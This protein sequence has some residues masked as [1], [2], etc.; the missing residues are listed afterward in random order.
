MCEP[1]LAYD[2]HIKKFKWP[3]Q[4]LEICNTEDIYPKLWVI[5]KRNWGLPDEAYN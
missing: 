5:P 3:D 1:G 4:L 2:D